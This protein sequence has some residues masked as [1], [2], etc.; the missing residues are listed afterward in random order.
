MFA[1]ADFFVAC[2]FS[3]R[4][5]PYENGRIVRATLG[6]LFSTQTIVILIGVCIVI[7]FITGLIPTYM[8]LRIPV[9]AAFRNFKESRRYWKLCLLFIQFFGNSLS[10]GIIVG[11]Q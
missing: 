11:Y 4:S 10:G 7:F 3:D 5:V 1:Y 9:A 6:A 8:F 2:R